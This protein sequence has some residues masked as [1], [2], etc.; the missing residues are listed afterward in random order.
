MVCA[1]SGIEIPEEDEFVCGGGGVLQKSQNP[2]H[3]RTDL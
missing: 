3:H 1:H 2:D